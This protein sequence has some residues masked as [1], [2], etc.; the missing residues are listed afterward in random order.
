MTPGPAIEPGPHTRAKYPMKV[1]HVV[2]LDQRHQRKIL[3]TFLG[4]FILTQTNRV[5][6]HVNTTSTP[7]KINLEFPL[8]VEPTTFRSLLPITRAIKNRMRT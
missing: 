3:G 2:N 1:P 8:Q 4:G 5:A 7:I 6:V